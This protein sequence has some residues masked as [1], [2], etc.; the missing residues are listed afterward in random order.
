MS[1]MRLSVDRPVTTIMLFLSIGLLGFISYTRIPQELFPSMEYPQ[2]TIVTR[3]DGAGPEEAEKLISKM[4][5]ETAGTV[6]DI[7]RV[8]SNSKEG[9]SIVT[10][11]FRWG[12][13]MDF[14]AMDVREKIDLIKESLPREA[15]DPVV[16][17]YNPTQTEAMLLSV[18]YK[19]GDSSDIRMA[20]LRH[21]A[22]R[23]IKDELERL[24]GVA[25]VELR[26][27]EEKEILVEIDKGR[28]LANQVS[29]TEVA[30]SLENANITYP[31]GTIKEEKHE[32][33]VKTVGEFQSI[34]DIANLSFS[35]VDN[36]IEHVLSTK[37][38]KNKAQET[39]D[40]IIFLK[41]IAE[42][43]ETLKD[44]KGYSRY[45]GSENISVGIYQQSG[46]NLINLS[47]E[48][49]KKLKDIK[50]K[51]PEDVD[52]KIT[53]DQSDFIKESLANL[54][55]NGI[56]GILLSFILLYFFMK[57]FIASTII[58][59]AIP[60]ALCSTLSFMYFGDISINTMSLGGLTVGIGMVI[61]NSNVVLENILMQF[62][63][64]KSI[65]K[66][67]RIYR[68]TS[69]LL[70][71][72]MSS[73]L[74]TLAIFIPFVF[75]A[76]MIGQLFKQLALTI[77]FSL[78]SSIFTALFLVPRLALTAD[79]SKQSIT[80]GM[81]SINKYFTPVFKKVLDYKISKI[82]SMIFIYTIVG[83]VCFALIP[84]AFMPKV[85]ERRFTLN[86]IMPPDTPLEAT[87]VA[88]KRIEKLISQYP[89][90]NDIS[91]SVGST[92]D[93]SGVA[94]I[95]SLGT[96]QSRIVGRLHKEGIST[97]EF[98][99]D[100]SN[101]IR[102]FNIKGLETEFM[103]QQGLFGSGVGAASGL[104]IEIRG[105][106]LSILKQA[107]DGIRDIMEKMPQ[108][109]G[110]KLD[111]PD[112]VPELRLTIDRERASLFGLSTQDISAM[113]L[114]AIKGYV[115]TKLKRKDDEMDVRVRMRP[116]DRDKLSKVMEMT[117]Y[118]Q[119]GMTIQLK[120]IAQ[121]NFVKT[122]PSIKR[123]EGERTYLLSANV[124]GNFAKAVQE[125]ET[126]L[127]ER[128][129]NE[130]V[131]CVI[132]G[133]ML[134]MKEALSQVSFALGLGVIIIFMVLASEFESLFQPIIVMTAIP[135]GIV[136]AAFVLFVTGQSI[137]SISMLGFIMLVGNVVNISI[138]LVDR[139]N[140]MYDEELKKADGNRL[141]VLVLKK[142]VVEVTVNHIRPITM[143]TLT[144]ITGLIPL[145]V[146]FGG[147]GSTNQPMAIAVVG[148][149]SFALVLALFFVPY[150]YLYTKGMRN[151]SS[152]ELLA[153]F[154]N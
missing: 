44:R 29:I 31:A 119:W 7:K 62:H 117:A 10:C 145:A 104:M 30:T 40:K 113:T 89:E 23:N 19:N 151:S 37:R 61:D 84:K 100:I 4:V 108:F 74:T 66:K 71:P 43:K 50:E 80:A 135:L 90:I 54:Y 46:S 28:L 57:S 24:E 146:G 88:T 110:I 139:F 49:Q 77:S 112:E 59:I 39:G 75:V 52:I 132:S 60:V 92:G 1:I 64:L 144:T 148:G 69:S 109:Y 45:N 95:E 8:S 51:M 13:N 121:A 94:A 76:G 34:D 48:V 78:V 143:T 53:S 128:Y 35:K 42:V 81:D 70:A 72:I 101:E 33:L 87:N 20:E 2:I 12:T 21:M 130:N 131:H 125:I 6:K 152:S 142:N 65:P 5:E 150:I 115:A 83:V 123:I 140:I 127:D 120:Q 107:S 91:V 22:K 11:E 103:T 126:I 122:L 96:Y 136:G 98:V 47:K 63:R 36:N 134:A 147:G 97:D 9:V 116:E 15:L 79:L 58:N 32:Y 41:D 16:L 17:K 129:N 26:G 154:K 18:S 55:S 102:K 111:P 82:M 149:L 93:D 99:A 14:A 153:S 118:S 124:K 73:T 114:A 86:I 3:Y 137:N 25:K 141:D 138:L 38:L 56:Q 27:G 85:D 105:S 133:E 67:E 106:D 68:A